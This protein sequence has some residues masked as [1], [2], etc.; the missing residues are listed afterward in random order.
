MSGLFGAAA[1]TDCLDVLFYGTD[2]QSHLG[3]QYGGMAVSNDETIVRKIHDTSRRQ[4]KSCFFDDYKSLRGKLGIGVISADDPQ[5][6]MLHSRFGDFAVVMDGNISNK[7]ALAAELHARGISFGD[8]VVGHINPTELVAKLI[9]LGESVVDGIEKM[10][11]RIQGAVSVLVLTRD[12]IYAARDRYGHSPLVIGQRNGVTAVATE[13][14]AFPNLELEARKFLLPGEIVHISEAGIS[15]RAQGDP[16]GQ[17]CAFLWIYTGFPASHYEKT[18]VEI[19]RERC[20]RCLAKDDAIEADLVAG[21]PDSGTAHAIGYAMGSGIPYRRPLVKYTAGYGRSYTPPSQEIRDLVAKMK[22]IPIKEVIRDSRIVIC[23][24]SIVRGT[25]FKNFTVA[26]LWS[27]GARAVHIRI[28]CPPLMH[29]CRYN[30]STRSIHELAARRA[31]RAIEG[32]VIEDV[33]EYTDPTTEKHRRMVDWIA[34]DLGVTS[35]R[36]LTADQVVD[37]IGLPRDRLCLYCW[38]GCGT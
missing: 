30:V 26:K 24:D 16:R 32:T 25:Q 37:A 11:D 5:P 34:N 1:K 9:S 27:C 29:P 15:Q 6:M 31:I 12:G 17:I 14:S 33:S 38:N 21:V 20:G 7:D 8:S 28:A 22:L 19:V 10:F 4:F 2:Y 35:L 13:T 36:Y 23:D 18:N 3:T